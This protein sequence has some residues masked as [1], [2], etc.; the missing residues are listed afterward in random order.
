MLVSVGG[1][2]RTA[3]KFAALLAAAAFRAVRTLEADAR[4]CVI[5]AVPVDPASRS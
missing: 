5:E 3:E 4:I 1:Q 2:E